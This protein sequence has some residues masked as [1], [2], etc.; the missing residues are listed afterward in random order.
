MVRER[1][2]T[3]W[4]QVNEKDQGRLTIAV[5]AAPSSDLCDTS[6]D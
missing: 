1:K 5:R 3:I 4:M 2:R 6:R